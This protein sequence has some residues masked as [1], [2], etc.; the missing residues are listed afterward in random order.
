MERAADAFTS[1]SDPARV[2][3]LVALWERSGRGW[4]SFSALRG[5]AGVSD[6]GRFSYHLDR[7]VG[8]FVRK[9][10]RGYRLSP[11]G[12]A[13]LDAV[14]AGSVSPA[15]EMP[16]VGADAPCPECDRELRARYDDG[17]FI[18]DCADCELSVTRFMFPPRGLADRT[19]AAAML[20]YSNRTRRQVAMAGVGVC[21]Y[22]GGC[23]DTRVVEGE[24]HYLT[25]AVRHDC[26]DCGGNVH[27]PPGLYLLEHA[28]VQA[29]LRDRGVDPDAR[30]FWTFEWCRSDR[31][32]SPREDGGGVEVTVDCAGDRLTLWLGPEGGVREPSADLD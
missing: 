13:A 28:R 27:E 22:C 18:V 15:A 1:L 31:T 5:A 16:T 14:Q 30:P 12:L 17:E 26:A 23:T 11:A 6:S 4:C 8:R 29:F 10:E 24:H 9:S 32:V 19:P 3:I 20:A 2:R 21:P 7:L 25:Y